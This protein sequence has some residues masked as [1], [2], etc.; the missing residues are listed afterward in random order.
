M[1]APEDTAM[2]QPARSGSS[3]PS[4]P[5]ASAA[6]AQHEDAQ[7]AAAEQPASHANEASGEAGAACLLKDVDG[8]AV[9]L[10]ECSSAA[11][12]SGA[13]TLITARKGHNPSKQMGPP[14]PDPPPAKSNL[15]PPAKRT[16]K[17]RKFILPAAPGAEGQPGE[18]PR[19]PVAPEEELQGA[20]EEDIARVNIEYNLTTPHEVGTFKRLSD[21]PARLS[22]AWHA[23]C[24]ASHASHA[25]ALMRHACAC[26]EAGR[27]CCQRSVH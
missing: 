13:R 6:A 27:G 21:C 25:G 7:G 4:Q 14:N 12:R 24:G 19:E 17:A 23:C 11:G 18:A 8:P 26:T 3:T 22:S 10:G 2:E 15:G 20:S 9:G 1:P 5:A 16:G